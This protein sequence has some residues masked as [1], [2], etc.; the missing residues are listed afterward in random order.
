MNANILF[1]YIG[2]LNAHVT[3]DSFP[4]VLVKVEKEGKF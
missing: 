4:D 3:K 1:C 2:V